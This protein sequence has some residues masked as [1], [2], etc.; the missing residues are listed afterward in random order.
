MTDSF[1]LPKI[2]LEGLEKIIIAYSHV[3]DN[4]T[5]DILARLTKMGS[6]AISRNNKFLMD[7]G[8]IAGAAE[9]TVTPLGQKLGHALEYALGADAQAYWRE[10]IS[11]N[12]AMMELI[13][14]E[15]IKRGM[16]E[17][18]LSAHILDVSVHKKHAHTQTGAR[19]LIDILLESGLLEQDQD[20]LVA[21]PAQPAKDKAQLFGL[22]AEDSAPDTKGS[23]PPA[24]LM[25][26]P[27]AGQNTT[28]PDMPYIML[29]LTLPETE[30]L[31]VY[32]KI[33]RA[34]RE[35]LLGLP[36]LP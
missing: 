18:D 35:N 28:R 33:F 10:A 7:I 21:A 17:K 32:E 15:D 3:P 4:P 31:A 5:L 8:V 1:H 14:T 6:A 30:D 13:T 36:P 23:A 12:S 20:M 19:C 25:G 29:N 22:Q 34:L 11:S 26:L 27:L 9:K 16:S 24:A 2:S